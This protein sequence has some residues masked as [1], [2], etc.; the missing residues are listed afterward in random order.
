MAEMHQRTDV[1][2][3]YSFIFFGS[4]IY[5]CALLA[6]A[7]AGGGMLVDTDPLWHLAAGDWIRA[8]GQLPFSDPWSFTTAGYQW[9]NISWGWDS[10]FSLIHQHLGWH[11][12]FVLNAITMA[13]T[14]ICSYALCAKRSSSIIAALITLVLLMPMLVINLRPL[15]ITALMMAAMLLIL[16]SVYRRQCH[17]YWLLLIPLF[18]A[19]WV[20]AHGGFVIAPIMVGTYFLQALYERNH[21]MLRILLATGIATLIAILCNP[22]QLGIIEAVWRPL[23][24]TANQIIIEWQPLSTSAENLLRYC[25]VIFFAIFANRKSGD[26]LLMERMLGFFWLVMA[27]TSTRHMMVFGVVA[28]PIVACGIATFWADMCRKYPR[29]PAAFASRYNSAIAARASVILCVLVTLWL[30][31]PHAAAIYRHTEINLPTLKPELDF[32][33]AHYPRAQLLFD[34]DIAAIAVYESHGEVPVFIDPRTETAFPPEVIKDYGRFLKA[35]DGWEDIFTK[36]D[37]DGLVIANQTIPGM[38][39]RFTQRKG[40][41]IAFKGPTA[42]VFVRTNHEKH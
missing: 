35:A 16:S 9:L 2:P 10:I 7:A 17:M 15:Q 34:F 28:A 19:L 23:T 29:L 31:T 32:I 26:V 30:P 11:G 42:T 38:L 13:T 37:I 18:T 25:L 22:Y 4:I 5:L 12:G 40:W 24:T 20:N 14:I 8:N 36:Y 41:K 3:R 21:T 27:L 33:S 39:D 6:I 1:F